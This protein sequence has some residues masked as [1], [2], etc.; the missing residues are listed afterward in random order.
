M[1]DLPEKDCPSGGGERRRGQTGSACLASNFVKSFPVTRM[2]CW[3]VTSSATPNRGT[4][5]LARVR[6]A[7]NWLLNTSCCN[8]QLQWVTITSP[9]AIMM[10]ICLQSMVDELMVK[11]SGDSIRKMLHQAG[12]GTLRCSDSQQAVSHHRCLS[13]QMPPGSPWSNSQTS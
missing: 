9:Q 11:Q 2:R 4:S 10:S 5:S 12:G 1:A 3:W 6:C 13:H 7:W 8:D